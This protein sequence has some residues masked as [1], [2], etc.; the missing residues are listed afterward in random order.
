TERETDRLFALVETAKANGTGII[1]IT[2]RMAEI[3][4]I[5]DLVTVLREGRKIATLSAQDTTEDQLIELM[6][7]RVIE[8]VFPKILF[9]PGKTMLEI[10]S[11]SLANGNVRDASITVRSGEVVGIA[12]LVGSGKS[13]MGRAAFGLD[14]I[15][16]GRI[17][18]K[19][20]DVT[21]RS[22]RSML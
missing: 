20:E 8:Q 14:R 6:T 15:R 22:V 7:G 5:A 19:G 11:L 1:Y 2:H 10:E 9:E 13:E 17:R 16:A 4:R 21:G 12:G 3:K 18:F